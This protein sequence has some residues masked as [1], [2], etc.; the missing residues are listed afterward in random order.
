MQ[1]CQMV[2]A[3]VFCNYNYRFHASFRRLDHSFAI[4]DIL[5]YLSQTVK[6]SHM[7]LTKIKRSTPHIN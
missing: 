5:C 7:Y 4:T 2:L 1:L 6:T 3:P